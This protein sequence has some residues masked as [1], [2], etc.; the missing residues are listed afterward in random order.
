MILPTGAGPTSSDTKIAGRQH[1]HSQMHLNGHFH[2]TPQHPL[3]QKSPQKTA[4]LLQQQA[5]HRPASLIALL[6]QDTI[7]Y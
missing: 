7:K 5:K 6:Q 2:H 3:F 1:L 4:F